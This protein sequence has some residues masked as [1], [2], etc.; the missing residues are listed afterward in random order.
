MNRF[1]IFVFD[2]PDDICWL[3]RVASWLFQIIFLWS[4]IPSSLIQVAE[5]MFVCIIVNWSAFKIAFV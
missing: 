4:Q 5:I 2:T 1:I 3:I